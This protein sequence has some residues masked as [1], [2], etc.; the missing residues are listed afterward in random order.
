MP[1]YRYSRSL[2]LALVVALPLVIASVCHAGTDDEALNLADATPVV[3]E[4]T[5]PWRI[6]TEAGLARTRQ[7]Y[8]LEDYNSARLSLDL[9]YDAIVKPGL[10]LVFSDRI[11]RTNASGNTKNETVNSLKEAYLSWHPEGNLI[12]DIGRINARYG[13]AF[14]Y[15]PTD[16]F[17]SSALRSITSIDPNSLREN[18]LG[19]GMLRTQALL[20]GGS[21]TAIYAPKLASTPNDKPFSADFGAT[22][23]RDRWLIAGSKQFSEN[24]NP[25]LM[26]FGG[27]G[28]SVQA[29]VNLSTLLNQATVGY[30]EWSGGM[31]QS[32][33]AEALGTN[34]AK[35]FRQRVAAGLTYTNAY[36]MSLTAEVDYNGAGLGKNEWLALAPMSPTNY[37]RYRTY[38]QDRLEL[39]T[40]TAL[41]LYGTWQNAF[42]NHLDLKAMVRMNLADRSRLNWIE[43]RYHFTKVDLSLQLQHNGGKAFSE[44]GGLPQRQKLQ[45]TVTYY[46]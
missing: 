28:Q 16:F 36:K 35:S 4:R 32:L 15:N 27:S 44:Y 19:T 10:R 17:R 13:A 38:A 40:R 41:F 31:S 3:Q 20:D 29:G 21:V 43:A 25:Q 33:Y 7:R 45:T 9:Y 26:L 22:N 6:S 39:P 11:D 14:G 12:G 1:T 18:R 34:Q 37:F 24:F 2:F 5:S 42:V 8:G 23:N 46:F 30:V